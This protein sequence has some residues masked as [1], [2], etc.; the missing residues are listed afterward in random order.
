MEGHFF[1]SGT[2]A[3]TRERTFGLSDF[4]LASPKGRKQNDKSKK[5]RKQEDEKRRKKK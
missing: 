5:A 3:F 2:R 1:T 4:I